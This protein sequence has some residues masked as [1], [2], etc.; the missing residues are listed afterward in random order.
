[1]RIPEADNPFRRSTAVLRFHV[2]VLPGG[3]ND[4]LIDRVPDLCLDPGI[5]RRHLSGALLAVLNPSFAGRPVPVNL[6]R[7]LLHDCC[8]VDDHCRCKNLERA[9]RDLPGSSGFGASRFGVSC[10]ENPKWPLR[11]RR[12]RVSGVCAV[13]RDCADCRLSIWRVRICRKCGLRLCVR[14]FANS[15]RRFSVRR[16]F[17]RDPSDF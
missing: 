9:I 8:D 17:C 5:C 6:G 3:L 2:P 14:L 10:V 13:D 7:G 1:R 16:S 4:R 12:S 11:G 15:V